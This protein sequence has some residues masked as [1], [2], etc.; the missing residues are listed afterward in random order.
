MSARFLTRSVL[1]A[2]TS[3]TSQPA[4]HPGLRT[5]LTRWSGSVL[6]LLVVQHVLGLYLQLVSPLPD[7]VGFLS[8]VASDAVLA[9]HV[10][11]AILILATT[12]VVFFLAALSRRVVL[13]APALVGLAITFAAFQ[14]GLE[15]IIGGQ[16]VVFSLP[17]GLL[18]LGVVGSDV[19]ILFWLTR[20]APVPRV[21]MQGLLRRIG[22][23]ESRS[24]AARAR[25]ARRARSAPEG[26]R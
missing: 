14:S 23:R 26:R 9:A 25:L 8:T 22:A 17:M 12:A 5:R 16:E 3:T 1:N 24:R 2:S 18:F 15:F 4:R 11:V 6:V 10:S 19:L 21:S 20:R 13:W 7:G